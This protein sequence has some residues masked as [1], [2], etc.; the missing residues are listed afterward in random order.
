MEFLLGDFEAVVV[1]SLRR[2]DDLGDLE[3]DLK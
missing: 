3:G 1:D 2:R